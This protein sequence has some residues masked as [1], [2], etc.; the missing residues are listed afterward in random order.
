MNRIYRNV[1]EVKTLS[2]VYTTMVGSNV[3]KTFLAELKG[4]VKL[5]GNNY[6]EV[7][8]EMMSDEMIG[9]DVE[10]SKLLDG[11]EPST[12]LNCHNKEGR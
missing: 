2:S 1:Y 10:A 6:D 11:E 9:A 4:L 5:S 3:T 8:R 12:Y 7:L